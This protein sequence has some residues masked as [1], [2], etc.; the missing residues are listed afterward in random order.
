MRG[1]KASQ[2]P[3]LIWLKEAG[4]GFWVGKSTRNLNSS[5]FYDEIINYNPLFNN[6]LVINYNFLFSSLLVINYNLLFSS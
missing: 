3:G 4:L 1:L 5:F 6:H 2:H